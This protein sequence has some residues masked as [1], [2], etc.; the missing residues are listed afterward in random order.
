MTKQTDL[1]VVDDDFPEGA[2]GM[3]APLTPP[4]KSALDQK[5]N[6]V[7]GGAVVRKDLVKAVKGNAIVPSSL[8]ISSVNTPHL[9]MRQ[10]S[11]PAS[12]A[13]ARSWRT[14]TCTGT[15]QS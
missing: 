10:R 9:M 7:F 11:S 5:I 13:F 4:M 3:P 15:S 14:T 6:D 1:A 8:S 2:A 12:R